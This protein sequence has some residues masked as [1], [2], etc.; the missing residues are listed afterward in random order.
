MGAIVPPTGRDRIVTRHRLA[1][2]LVA[3]AW[4]LAVASVAAAA[5]P[6]PAPSPSPFVSSLEAW[7][8]DDLPTDAPAG[9]PLT[10]GATLWMPDQAELLPMSGVF[11][12][13]RPASGTAAPTETTGILDWPGH[14]T[15]SL[16]VPTGGVGDLEIGQ[17]GSACDA[18]GCHR[19]DLLFVIAGVGPPPDAALPQIATVRIDPPVTTPTAGESVGIGMILTL[20]ADWDPFAFA[21]PS[22]LALQ[23]SVPRGPTIDD[24]AAPLTDPGT[25]RYSASVTFPDAGRYLLE[26]AATTGAAGRDT[27]TTSLTSVNVVAGQPSP[28]ATPASDGPASA[29]ADTQVDPTLVAGLLIALGAVIASVLV[30]GAVGDR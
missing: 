5:S 18:T 4:G 17:T 22:A 20:K 10:I 23:V 19:V 8:D 29:G 14:V 21:P 15:A 12:R 2:G 1:A 7:L 28:V 30:V 3:A 9:T 11:V 27:F 26:A 25:L 16:V 13:L 24:V 6:S